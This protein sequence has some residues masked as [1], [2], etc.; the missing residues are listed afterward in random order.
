MQTYVGCLCPVR[1]RYV[2][3]VPRDVDLGKL[4]A[5]YGLSQVLQLVE[6]CQR[7]TREISA[8]LLDMHID[9]SFF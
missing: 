4:R 2:P 3:H 5:D 1:G 9:Q 8:N 7:G 6:N